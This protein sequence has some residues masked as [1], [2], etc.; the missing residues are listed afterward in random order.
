MSRTAKRK[1][2]FLYSLLLELWPNKI[3][4]VVVR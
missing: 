3:N 2:F 1:Q 4:V